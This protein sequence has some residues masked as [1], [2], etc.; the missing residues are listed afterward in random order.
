MHELEKQ[1]GVHFPWH[2]DPLFNSRVRLIKIPGVGYRIGAYSTLMHILRNPVYIGTWKTG[3]KAYP[4]RHEAIITREIWDTVQYLL[5]KRQ[6]QTRPTHRN[7]VADS[8]LK[9]LILRP[10]PGWQVTVSPVKGEINF[11]WKDGE[12]LMCPNRQDILPLPTVETMF[13]DA[14]TRRLL[15]DTKC[16]E[17][18]KAATDLHKAAAKDREH[19]Q[20][21]IN[22]LEARRQGILDD[23]ENPK[24]RKKMSERTIEEK[25]EKVADMEG[26]ISRLQ[27]VLNK[28]TKY[29]PLPE[30][31]TLIEQLRENWD[32]LEPAT[33]RNAALVFCK[34]I[35]LQ[36]RSSHIWSFE[37]Q[38]ELWPSDNGIIWL[39]FGT[40]YHWNDADL[41]TLQELTAR[42]APTTEILEALPTYSQVAISDMSLRRFGKRA[43]PKCLY[44]LDTY[45][46]RQDVS[47]LAQYGIGVERIAALKGAVKARDLS[48]G[49]YWSLARISREKQDAIFFADR[50]SDV[51][52]KV[53]CSIAPVNISTTVWA[54]LL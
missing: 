35:L 20:E 16:Y 15:Q 31:L 23:L 42:A 17:Y 11:A 33:I 54:Y 21:T 49:E 5:D 10:F 32:S 26:E 34:G 14:F 27:A 36:P 39:N 22:G 48:G 29:I 44:R 50:N 4:D 6:A 19:I 43:V 24:M 38:W 2:D 53:I 52:S 47:I 7:H 3:D 37:I 30:L 45:M 41:A 40:K 46:T 51:N 8:I 12:N 9:G 1:E 25:Y 13:K 18:A 28:P